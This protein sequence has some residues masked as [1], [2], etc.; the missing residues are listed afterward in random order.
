ME[1][2]SAKKKWATRQVVV[3]AIGSIV[4]LLWMAYI[5]ATLFSVC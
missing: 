3:F 1:E 5:M 4:A 2:M